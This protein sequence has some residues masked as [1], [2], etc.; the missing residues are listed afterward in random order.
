MAAGDWGKPLITEFV[1]L[2]KNRPCL[3]NQNI[4]EYNKLHLREAAYTEIVDFLKQ[5]GLSN[6]TDKT[7]KDKIQNLRRMH[8]RERGKVEM[9]K[10]EGGGTSSY[11]PTLWYYDLFAFLNDDEPVGSCEMES[12][13]EIIIENYSE[14][15]VYNIHKSDPEETELK[16]QHKT[17]S[18]LSTRAIKK[19]KMSE[20][21]G[22][23][24]TESIKRLNSEVHCSKSISDDHEALGFIVTSKIKKMKTEQQI[25]AEV[26]IHKILGKG[27][28]GQL[29]NMTDLFDSNPT[30][31]NNSR[32]SPPV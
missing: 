19:L 24:H 31:Q 32:F 4:L 10:K 17:P 18:R 7:V 13:P 9:S 1:N 15:D 3:W 6:A 30:T 26:L 21:V 5:N 14:E 25:Y 23:P 8:R 20:I 28:L 12:Y 22:S 16:N 29:N 2:Y 27:L 11:V